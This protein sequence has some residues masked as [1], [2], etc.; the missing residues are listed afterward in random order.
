MTEWELGDAFP[1][2]PPSVPAADPMRE[3]LDLLAAAVAECD[4][5]V[6]RS[7]EE[8][9]GQTV[10]L[11]RALREQR[12]VLASIEATVEAR[13]VRL[14]GKGKHEQYGVKVNGGTS[15]TWTDPRTLAWRVA[16]PLV[17]DRT[18]GETWLDPQRV[19]DIIDRIFDAVA[20][21]YFRTGFL[22]D[23]GVEYDDLVK[24]EPSR[25]TVQILSP[26]G[27]A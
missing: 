4:Q 17:I 20:F 14:L 13:V 19:G 25:R 7:V 3:A 21:S 26:A 2:E 8:N 27:D 18:S 22:R 16:E 23:L 24:R 6:G 10:A 12:Q 11:L 9:P 1:N 5:Q 15:T